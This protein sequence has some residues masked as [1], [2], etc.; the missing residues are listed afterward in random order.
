MKSCS[1]KGKMRLQRLLYFARGNEDKNV[2]SSLHL[3]RAACRRLGVRGRNTCARSRFATPLA[4]L[5]WNEGLS[6]FAENVAMRVCSRAFV[7]ICS[8]IPYFK[9]A[10]LEKIM[11]V[12]REALQGKAFQE[13]EADN[14]IPTLISLICHFILPPRGHKHEIWKVCLGLKCLRF[15]PRFP[16]RPL[17]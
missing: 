16:R 8:W 15:P 2:P 1:K 11:C 17:E 9:F 3:S 7:A 10:S 13:E 14:E 6:N 4:H 5:T 12:R